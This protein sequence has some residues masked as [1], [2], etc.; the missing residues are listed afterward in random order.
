MQGG[1]QLVE[2][3]KLFHNCKDSLIHMTFISNK[4]GPPACYSRAVWEYLDEKCWLKCKG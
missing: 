2:R 4:M 1:G 3:I